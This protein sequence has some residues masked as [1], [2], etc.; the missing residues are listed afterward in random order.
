MVS[1]SLTCVELCSDMTREDSGNYSCEVRGPHSVLLAN[2]TH[3]V[4]VRGQLVSDIR[5]NI[6]CIVEVTLRRWRSFLTVLIAY[7]CSRSILLL[8]RTDTLINVCPVDEPLHV[9]Y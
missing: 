8:N 4:F 3:Q 5:L 2:V 9:C 1:D 7:V 6:C